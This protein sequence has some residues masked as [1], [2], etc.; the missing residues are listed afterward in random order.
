[1]NLK[2]TQKEAT[3]MNIIMKLNTQHTEI[4][5]TVQRQ[6][7][8]DDRLL[9]SP[10]PQQKPKVLWQY[11]L[12]VCLFLW[13]NIFKGLRGNNCNQRI[14]YLAESAFKNTV[15]W[16]RFYN[17]Q[18]SQFPSKPGRVYHQKSP[19][20]MYH[21]K[22]P[23]KIYVLGRWKSLLTAKFWQQW[24]KSEHNHRKQGKSKHWFYKS[25][26]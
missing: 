4:L 6:G 17:S 16:R 5:K 22:E 14:V 25:N 15:K 23:R 3:S 10:R 18:L 11:F 19:H 1:M 9:P 20:L 26:I 21:P 13:D 7:H 2:M 24:R 8:R 12:F